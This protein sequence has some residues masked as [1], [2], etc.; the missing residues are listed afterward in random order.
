MATP[1]TGAVPN[2]NTGAATFSADT[3]YYHAW[4]S[5]AITT[6]NA[7][8]V[9]LNSKSAAATT[10]ATT[11][12]N[13]ATIATNQATTATNQATI[14][15]N[16]A[17]T[18]TTQA[19]AA[20]ASASSASTSASTATT[21][22]SNASASATAAA[23]SYDSFDD[24]Y[25]GAKASNPTLDNDGNALLVGALYF[26]STSSTMLN[27]TGSA[28]VSVAAATTAGAVVN[29]P[30]GNIAAITVQEALNELDT[31]KAN[32]ASP[33][34]T[35]VPAAPTAAAATNTAQLATTAHV[36]AERI[37]TAT[38]TNK[39]FTNPT[40]TEQTLTDAVT[41]TW[42]MSLGHV[43]I[44]SITATGRTLA[45]PTNSKVGGQYQLMISLVTPATMT[46]TWP[47][48]FKFPYD[49][50]PDLT[51]STWTMLTLVWSAPHSKFLV[52][53]APGF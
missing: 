48:I 20:S 52:S 17:A 7:D 39:T 31:E 9:D 37:N 8:I 33:T 10:S 30:A 25:L 44:W 3:D 32:I 38:L 1:Y 5:G 2:R 41:T 27:W 19:S 15:T 50:A 47:V 36:F 53:Y 34:F 12:T 18:S 42:D 49:T 24:R 22:A 6:W 16:Q 13:Q 43:A 23:A 29:T 4:L 51:T 35:G 21:Q 26:N 28:W 46:P 45:A 40:N 11:A 14:A